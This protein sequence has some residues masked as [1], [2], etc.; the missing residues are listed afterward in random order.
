MANLTNLPREISSQTCAGYALDGEAVCMAIHAKVSSGFNPWRFRARGSRVVVFN[1]DQHAHAHVFRCPMSLW[2]RDNGA[3]AKE[4]FLSPLIRNGTL[5]PRIER[6]KGSDTKSRVTLPRFGNVGHR[7][8][9]PILRGEL[10]DDIESSADEQ[11]SEVLDI[12][13]A[14]KELDAILDEPATT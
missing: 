6:W 2:E 7:S 5:I 4:I 1:Y 13:E 10:P 12:D 8:G 11:D 14:L 3:L 9:A